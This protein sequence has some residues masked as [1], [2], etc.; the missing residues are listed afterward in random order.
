MSTKNLFFMIF[1]AMIPIG[2]ILLLSCLYYIFFN[3][4]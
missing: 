4:E 3:E 2:F 1:G